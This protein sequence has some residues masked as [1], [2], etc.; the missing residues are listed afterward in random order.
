M[1]FPLKGLT[2]SVKK[3]S[4]IARLFKGAVVLKFSD[5]EG[6]GFRLTPRYGFAPQD[7][8]Q[9][10]GWLSSPATVG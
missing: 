9:L 2:T 6:N 1:Q 5:E 8:L 3:Y 10:Y 4:G 7:L